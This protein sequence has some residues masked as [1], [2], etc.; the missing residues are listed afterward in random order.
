MVISG[1]CQPNKSR[2]EAIETIENKVNDNDSQA[3]EIERQEKPGKKIDDEVDEHADDSMS[4]TDTQIY[5]KDASEYLKKF[6]E[7]IDLL[8]E[9]KLKE[10]IGLADFVKCNGDLVTFLE[11]ETI[12]RSG[13][14]GC[15][16]FVIVSGA[17]NVLT[18]DGSLSIGQLSTGDIFG[19]ISTLF[20]LKCTATIKAKTDVVVVLIKPELACELFENYAEDLDLIDWCIKNR[21]LPMEKEIDIPR[22]YRRMALQFLTQVP[23][24]QSWSLDDLKKLIIS[25]DRGILTVY[26]PNSMLVSVDDPLTSLCIV[27][28]GTLKLEGEGNL[29]RKIEVTRY[30]KP[31]IYGHFCTTHDEQ[32]SALTIRAITNCQVIVIDRDWILNTVNSDPDKAAS[33]GNKTT[34]LTIFKQKIAHH[35]KEFGTKLN[36]DILFYYIGHCELYKC[37]DC[38][39][40]ESKLLTAV[41]EEFKAGDTV[42]LEVEKGIYESVF[43]VSGKIIQSKAKQARDMSKSAERD[44][45]IP[46][47]EPKENAH[48]ELRASETGE[49]GIGNDEE[50]NFNDESLKDENPGPHEVFEEGVVIDLT[51]LDTGMFLLKAETRCLV[52]KVKKGDQTEDVKCNDV[53]T[54]EDG[55]KENIASPPETD[56][57][58]FV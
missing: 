10:E 38:S 40:I 35:A 9:H 52:G 18:A 41:F 56:S 25:F 17:I 1:N 49:N 55:H 3:E 24:F 19:D 53:E 31:F 37:I 47:I 36:Y 34:R 20:G 7:L 54:T 58:Q 33:L 2:S 28:R 42:V 43:V 23:L 39:A 11:G 8:Q 57:L 30:E 15:G 6:L 12:L 27:T 4:L 45:E 14:N 26:P 48:G 13:E 32:T 5:F 21:Y 50:T 16:L 44:S 22:T 51:V 46:S 29:I